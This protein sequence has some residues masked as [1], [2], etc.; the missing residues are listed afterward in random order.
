MPRAVPNRMLL[1]AAG[2]AW[3]QLFQEH[4]AAYCERHRAGRAQPRAH[5]NLGGRTRRRRPERGRAAAEL[6]KTIRKNR[7]TR[8]VNQPNTTW[9]KKTR[10]ASS[11][12]RGV[13]PARP[14]HGT[15]TRPGPAGQPG[16]NS[17][18]AR[19]GQ[20]ATTPGEAPRRSRQEC[21]GS[22]HK[23]GDTEEGR[24]RAMV[25]ASGRSSGPGRLVQPRR[26]QLR[27]AGQGRFGP[28]ARRRERRLQHTKYPGVV[29]QVR[30]SGHRPCRL[31]RDAPQA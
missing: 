19:R 20:F 27:E 17:A 4:A 30:S 23:G 10:P 13:W 29:E 22:S 6:Q 2:P 8:P 1:L 3:W 31:T 11:A 21:P 7:E 16:R 12:C 5:C 28:A 15:P 25:A 18:I 26:R 14:P 24:R 9:R